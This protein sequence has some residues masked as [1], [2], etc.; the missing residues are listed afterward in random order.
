MS[1]AFMV[2]SAEDESKANM[3]IW[4]A[5]GGQQVKELKVPVL[6]NTKAVKKGEQLLVYR[7]KVEAVAAEDPAE[8]PKKKARKAT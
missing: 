8:H 6:R 7:P 3:E 1:P 4:P 2:R 5:L